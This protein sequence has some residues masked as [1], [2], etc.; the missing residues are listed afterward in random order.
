[1]MYKIIT[2]TV[3]IIGVYPQVVCSFSYLDSLTPKR[4]DSS[5]GKGT[6]GIGGED[7]IPLDVKDAN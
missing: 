3:S 6:N 5:N 4:P 2:T 7:I 1:M